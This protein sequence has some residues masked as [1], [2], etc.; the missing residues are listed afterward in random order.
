MT[1]QP[2]GPMLD[3]LGVTLDLDEGQQLTE[4]FVIGKVSDFESGGT[5][6][7]L[8]TSEGLD[9]IG[10]RGLLD[11]ARYTLDHVGVQEA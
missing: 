5:G 3:A 4:A 9:W 1:D 10:Q 2:A 8:G 7:V 6:L 11:A